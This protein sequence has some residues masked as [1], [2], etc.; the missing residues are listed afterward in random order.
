MFNTSGYH[1]APDHDTICG[2]YSSFTSLTKH[3]KLINVLGGK[4]K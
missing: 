1:A 3:Q 4:D 2:L